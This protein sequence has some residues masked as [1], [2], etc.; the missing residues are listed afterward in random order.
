MMKSK[1]YTVVMCEGLHDI[2]FITR[3]LKMNG[4]SDEGGELDKLDKRFRAF[5]TKHLNKIKEKKE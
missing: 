2:A 5:F 1:W 4:Y 3:I